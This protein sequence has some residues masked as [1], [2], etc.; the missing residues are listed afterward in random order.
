[1][2]KGVVYKKVPRTP[3]KHHRNHPRSLCMAAKQGPNVLFCMTNRT[4]CIP[5][6]SVMGAIAFHMSRDGVMH[7]SHGGG[8]NAKRRCCDSQQET[9][10][11]AERHP[12]HPIHKLPSSHVNDI[13]QLLP[14]VAEVMRQDP[15]GTPRRPAPACL[16]VCLYVCLHVCVCPP[17]PVGLSVCLP[18]PACRARGTVWFAPAPRGRSCCVNGVATARG[19]RS[20][21]VVREG[22]SVLI[23]CAGRRQCECTARMVA[24]LLP[25]A[26]GDAAA[27]AFAAAAPCRQAAAAKLLE[28]TGGFCTDG[29]QNVFLRGAHAV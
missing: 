7:V 10:V 11:G 23:F 17:A 18:A 16:S 29:L 25:H 5:L 28:A 19:A 20:P 13:D 26:L 1:V 8:R 3:A 2:F 4:K 27:A 14:L 22:H 9:K 21:Q 6:V 12:L 15:T 24:D